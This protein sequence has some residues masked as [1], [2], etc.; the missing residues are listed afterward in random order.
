MV[1]ILSVLVIL[2]F[3]VA[4]AKVPEKYSSSKY[5]IG[6]HVQKG[7]DWKTTWH[8]RSNIEKNPL[9]K[10][11]LEYISSMTY[12]S[13]D[14]LDIN[15]GQCHSPK[16]GVKKLDYSYVVSEA[17]GLET[18][19]TKKI[20]K[21]MDNE[22]ANDGISCIICHNI[23]KIKHSKNINQRGFEAVEFG[24]NNIMNGPFDESNRTTY[25]KMQ[26]RSYFNE[27]V[28]TLC[29][30]CH[31]GYKE[32]NIY[33]YSTGVEYDSSKSKE[34]CADCHMGKRRPSIV[35]PRVEGATK[36]VQRLTRRH[37][38]KGARNS[39][40]LKD[41]MKVDVGSDRAN[42]FVTI[43]NLTPHK[44][45]TGFTGRE[46][47]LEVVFYHNSKKIKTQT[48]R[49]NTLYVDK[50]NEETLAYIAKKLVS[51]TR[52]KP[53]EARKYSVKNPVGATRAEINIWYRLV[54][55]SLVPLLGV[56]DP[57]FLKK[58]EIYQASIKL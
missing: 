55:K 43:K 7:K 52:L 57:L 56:T 16:M 33:V 36:A 26:K 18:K 11:T 40:I 47:V 5:C 41:S 13:V 49:I 12:K 15:C 9:Y 35:A 1:R 51:D 38:F 10:K 21:E 31:E 14:D 44:L 58:Y 22:T 3:Q 8:S 37:L 45:P 42:T 29:K 32:H 24:K 28:N 6:C 19:E 20:H 25:H 54:K 53:Y 17:F 46:L 27:D 2:V 50:N 4:Y 23:D 30:V 39:D 48:K 34:K